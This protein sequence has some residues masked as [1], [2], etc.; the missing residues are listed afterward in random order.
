MQRQKGFTLVEMLVVLTIF[1]IFVSLIVA[2]YFNNKPQFE[3]NGAASEL[4][5]DLSW[6]RMK[7]VSEN[8]NYAI[9]FE[10]AAHTYRIY[11]DTDNDFGVG[12]IEDEELVKTVVISDDY[13]DVIFGFLTEAGTLS[14]PTGG[15]LNDG[16]DPVTFAWNG[17]GI[18]WTRFEPN[19][20]IG[21]VGGGIYLILSDDLQNGISRMRA[22]TIS[23]AGRI[24]I[25]R[26]E[27]GVGWK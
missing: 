20:R 8:N 3:L 9:A 14:K 13:E 16:D 22:I 5:G 1:F 26:Y 4:M 10:V 25:W 23:I 7:A 24:K 12:N 19:G 27:K 17:G 18:R 15:N 11:D 2:G 21:G 6:A